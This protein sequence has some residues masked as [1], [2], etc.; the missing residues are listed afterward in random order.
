MEKLLGEELNDIWVNKTN[1]LDQFEK[2]LV[3]FHQIIQEISS[4][5]KD[6]VFLIFFNTPDELFNQK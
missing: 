6:S 4:K 2:R 1:T 3:D 5:N